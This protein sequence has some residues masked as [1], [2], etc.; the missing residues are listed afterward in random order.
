MP[1]PL[2]PQHCEAGVVKARPRA[3]GPSENRAHTIPITILIAAAMLVSTAASLTGGLIMYKE[4]V[5]SLEETVRDTSL[6]EL[7]SVA[8][9][10]ESVVYG[11]LDDGKA[12]I[13]TM[14]ASSMLDA[15]DEEQWSEVARYIQYSMIKAKPATYCLGLAAMP[16]AGEEEK[17]WYTTTWCDPLKS[18][19]CNMAVGVRHRP[20]HNNSIIFAEGGN[21]SPTPTYAVRY[22]DGTLGDFMYSWD[23]NE[24][25]VQSLIPGYDAADRDRDGELGRMHLGAMAWFTADY[26]YAYSGWNVVFKPPP[27]PHPWSQFEGIN[28]IALY[29]YGSWSSVM[30][31]YRKRYG[32]LTDIVILD[33][34]T[35]GV[36]GATTGEQMVDQG[37]F[38]DGEITLMS[39]CNVKLRNM[40]SAV[41]EL[42]RSY[43]SGSSREDFRALALDGTHYFTRRRPLFNDVSIYWMR[44]T[45]AV[46]DKVNDALILL[47][48]FS[49][50]IFFFDV[51]ISA[52]EMHFIATPLADVTDTFLLVAHMET[53]AAKM[54]LTKQASKRFMVREVHRLI[55]FLHRTVEDMEEYRSYLPQ[56]VLNQVGDEQH[57]AASEDE[58]PKRQSTDRLSERARALSVDT[59]ATSRKR[60]LTS[61]GLSVPEKRR[62]AKAIVRALK[63]GLVR[64][65]FTLAFINMKRFLQTQ[66]QLGD[67]ASALWLLETHL[68]AVLGCLEVHHGVLE[69]FLGDHYVGSFNASVLNSSHSAGGIRCAVDVTKRVSADGGSG[70][71]AAIVTGTGL[72]G[73]A[74][75]STTR[76]YTFI[77]PIY[78]FGMALLEVAKQLDVGT[79][80]PEERAEVQFGLVSEFRA[81]AVASCIYD[82]IKDTVYDVREIL[83]LHDVLHQEWMYELNQQE[84]DPCKRWDSWARAV[85]RNDWDTAD[86]ELEH[87][88]KYDATS[89]VALLFYSAHRRRCYNPFDLGRPYALQA[90]VLEGSPCEAR[91]V[92]S[93]KSAQMKCADNLSGHAEVTDVEELDA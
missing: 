92:K 9:Q 47:V 51:L 77:T 20:R 27:P 1:N 12:M 65:R 45:A 21:L 83:G 56:S 42:H 33:D 64:K 29:Q 59:S 28:L 37:C 11:I 80:V 26:V 18:G 8:K 72:A 63:C 55:L 40:S 70:L 43:N 3:D 82:K 39:S 61:T 5:A 17:A 68:N 16:R 34:V 7:D 30:D 15:T 91:D 93:D 49:V 78:G 31:A 25:F 66:T 81:R 87:A 67:A 38:V 50:M 35:L 85:L 84:E 58:R 76:K 90:S 79:V 71:R 53:G 88:E 6:S 54:A 19:G 4:S 13:N 24:P 73:N 60:S 2:A 10:I 75:N 86:A 74:G 41:Q 89:P 23:S 36:Y 44:P 57:E 32:E 48:V 52:A 62:R 14:Y 46:N 22:E 69:S